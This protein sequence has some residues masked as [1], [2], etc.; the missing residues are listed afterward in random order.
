V[1][2]VEDVSALWCTA[3]TSTLWDSATNLYARYV[4]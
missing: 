3:E 4:C 1:S 2:S